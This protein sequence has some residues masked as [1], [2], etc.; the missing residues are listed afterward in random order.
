[1]DETQQKETENAESQKPIENSNDGISPI[2]EAKIVLAE[3]QKA[4]LEMQKERIR[5]EKA[6]SE[7]LINGN[8]RAGQMPKV[9]TADEKWAR[10]AKVRYAGTG[11]DPTK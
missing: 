4:L 2:E 1:M 3:T 8:T 10:E 6:T 9:E 7:M 11:L 5:I